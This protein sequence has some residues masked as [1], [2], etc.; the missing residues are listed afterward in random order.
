MFTC[1]ECIEVPKEL[2]EMLK[3]EKL[4][5]NRDTVQEIERIKG[6]LER[7]ENIAKVQKD[8]IGQR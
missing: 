2:V 4:D 7:T 6:D 5:T 3:Y 8:T 1:A